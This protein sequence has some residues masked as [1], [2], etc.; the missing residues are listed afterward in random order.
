M[1][2]LN[3]KST[4]KRSVL[5]NIKIYLLKIDT[6]N[7]AHIDKLNPSPKPFNINFLPP[8]I[9]NSCMDLKMMSRNLFLFTYWERL[10]DFVIPFEPEFY[11]FL[12]Q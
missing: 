5:F 8:F 6:S 7:S 2:S 12:C 11:C 10:C 9:F 3:E 4:G 1:K